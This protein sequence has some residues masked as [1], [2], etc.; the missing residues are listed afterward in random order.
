MPFPAYGA[1][2]NAFLA[3][4]LLQVVLLLVTIGLTASCVSALHQQSLEAPG[5]LIGHLTI[6]VLSTVYSVLTVILYIESALPLLLAAFCDAFFFLAYISISILA[7]ESVSSLSCTP[8]DINIQVPNYRGIVFTTPVVAR[9]NHA[10]GVPVT[11]VKLK[12]E[13]TREQGFTG[14]S[15]WLRS[16]QSGCHIMKGAWAVAM[17]IAV[18]FLVTW[19]ASLGIWRRLHKQEQHNKKSRAASA[20]KDVE[21]WT[22]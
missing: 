17:G 19:L 20:S 18:L 22:T 5:R 15:L 6:A 3:S 12:R 9:D 21:H 8:S 14:F 10:S 7:A 13:Q 16:S 2:G 4:R 11:D 1:L